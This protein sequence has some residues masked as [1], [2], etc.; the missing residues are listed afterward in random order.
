VAEGIQINNADR[1]AIAC[2]GEWIRVLGQ[3]KAEVG[4][5]AY[6]NWLHPMNLD[7]VDDGQAV[8]LAPSRFLR[9]WV[10]T[11]DADRLLALW[12]AEN[13]RVTR[14]SSSWRY[15]RDPSMVVIRR[16][17]TMIRNPP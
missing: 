13:Q 16:A 6:R 11:H 14:V 9:D 17:R 7:R 1:T 15:P 2:E 12:Q 10:T 5:D 8:I 3:I 4:E